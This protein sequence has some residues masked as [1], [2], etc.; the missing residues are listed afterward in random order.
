MSYTAKVK[1]ISNKTLVDICAKIGKAFD[2]DTGGDKSFYEV[3][4][5]LETEFYAIP[6]FADQLQLLIINPEALYQYCIDDYDKRW[7]DLIPPTLEECTDFVE[8]TTL[9]ITTNT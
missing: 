8:K 6:L 1:L 7:A 5:H 2:P 4:D 9:T 3:E